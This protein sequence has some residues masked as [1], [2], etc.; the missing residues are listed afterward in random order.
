MALPRL[1]S[2]GMHS[3]VSSA[4]MALVDSGVQQLQDG[5]MKLLLVLLPLFAAPAMAEEDPLGKEVYG[6]FGRSFL[7]GS[8][9]LKRGDLGRACSE[10]RAANKVVDENLRR[11]Q[12]YEPNHDWVDTRELLQGVIAKNCKEA[13]YPIRRQPMQGNYSRLSAT[14]LSI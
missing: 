3:T 9:F 12:E 4:V 8:E 10:F 11:L 13:T 5:G 14:T 6:L 2:R 1:G 7:N